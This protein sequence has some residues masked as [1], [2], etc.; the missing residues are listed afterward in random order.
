MGEFQAPP[1][2]G[3]IYFLAKKFQGNFFGI[4]IIS[5]AINLLEGWD[6]SHLKSENRSSVWSTK[7]F[8]NDIREVSY[9]QNNMEYKI[10]KQCSILKSETAVIY[11]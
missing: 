11:E 2:F 10:S 3:K 8:L 9:E 1:F 6:I 5:P 4:S 7:T